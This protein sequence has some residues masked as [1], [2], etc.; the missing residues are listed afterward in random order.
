MGKILDGKVRVVMLNTI[1]GG[2]SERIFCS[3]E[4]GTAVAVPV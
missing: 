1:P 2:A 3:N 4:S